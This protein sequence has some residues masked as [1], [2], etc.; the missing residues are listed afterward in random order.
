MLLCTLII[1]PKAST[2]RLLSSRQFRRRKCLGNPH[3]IRTRCFLSYRFLSKR[4]T[5]AWT[6]GHTKQ[7]HARLGNR[8]GAVKTTDRPPMKWA[9]RETMG[10]SIRRV[11]SSSGQM[12]AGRA[13]MRSRTAHQCS[14]VHSRFLFPRRCPGFRAGLLIKYLSVN[15]VYLAR[16]F[17]K[18]NDRR[19]E[20]V[21]SQ[22]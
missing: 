6:V 5:L 18:A 1:G 14:H 16:H 15:N 17:P 11:I 12:S 13:W 19:G 20:H 10:K 4:S 9:L 2:G 8:L 7:H 3:E 21:Q 22:V